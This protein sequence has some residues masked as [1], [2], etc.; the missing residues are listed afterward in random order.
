MFNEGLLDRSIRILVGVALISLV[1]FGPKTAWGWF[2]LVP[3]VT[4]VIGLCP[5][6]TLLGIR[7]NR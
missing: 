5:L 6:Y 2:G 4:G 7:T 3:L 1:F